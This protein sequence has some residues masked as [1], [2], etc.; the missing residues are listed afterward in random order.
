[1]GNNLQITL[2]QSGEI[3]ILHLDGRLD[4]PGADILDSQ[5][6][7]CRQAGSRYFLLDFKNV[8]AVTGA[9]LGVVLGIYKML[10]PKKDADPP[11]S[12]TFDRPFKTPYLKL[13][14]LSPAVYYIFNLA[15]FLQNIAIY[16][17]LESALQ[18]FAG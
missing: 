12:P 5:A 15:G 6:R 11:N 8:S 17:D 1:M 14:N 18:S 13:A 9:G 10:N 3:T 16:E 7:Q 2:E 4:P